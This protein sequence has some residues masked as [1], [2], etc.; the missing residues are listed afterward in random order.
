MFLLW[1]RAA[2]NQKIALPKVRTL[3]YGLNCIR[4]RSAC[5][6]N[7]LVNHFPKDKFQNL[8]KSTC[9]KKVKNILIEGYN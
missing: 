4:Y 3:D 7:T 5:D 1:T 6:W 2:A 9:Q 8:S